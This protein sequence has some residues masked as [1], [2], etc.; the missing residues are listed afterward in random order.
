MV[1]DDFNLM[2]ELQKSEEIEPD[3]KR[4]DSVFKTLLNSFKKGFSYILS[5]GL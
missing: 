4:K 3:V 2:I 1:E 5:W